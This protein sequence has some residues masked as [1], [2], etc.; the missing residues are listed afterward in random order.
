[1]SWHFNSSGLLFIFN[2]AT[3][4]CST[5]IFTVKLYCVALCKQ[6]W[7]SGCTAY[8][9]SSLLYCL[10]RHFLSVLLSASCFLLPCL[11]LC[12]H[13]FAS[14][15]P[16]LYSLC[17]SFSICHSCSFHVPAHER[18]K[19]IFIKQHPLK[20]ITEFPPH[21]CV[22]LPAS[23]VAGN[24]VTTSLSFPELQ[25]WI[26]SRIVCAQIDD[27]TVNMTF[28]HLDIKCLCVIFFPL[29]YGTMVFTLQPPNPNQIIKF[30]EENLRCNALGNRADGQPDNACDLLIK[31]SEKT[32]WM[33]KHS[34]TL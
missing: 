1:M 7:N 22:P 12:H 30:E 6:K 33:R 4:R 3:L 13:L 29:C 15:F 10:E 25:C 34:H 18:F 27:D 9:W 26:M 24:L 11:F 28:A 20:K 23:Q 17:P 31:H 2:S 8:I 16:P 21:G 32:I 19:V 14:P 5:N